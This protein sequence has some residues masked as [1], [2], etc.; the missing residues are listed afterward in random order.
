M[1]ELFNT[2]GTLAQ[3]AKH[4]LGGASG[5]AGGLGTLLTDLM[6]SARSVQGG[7]GS[8]PAPSRS[9]GLGFGSP[10]DS[11]FGSRNMS[12][13]FRHP[14]TGRVED[15]PGGRPQSSGPL[16]DLAGGAGGLLGSAALG[17]V[18]G[19]LL[20]NRK[21]RKVVAS[22][23]KNALLL[24]GGA[25]IAGMAWGMFKKWSENSAAAPSS[26]PLPSGPAS[27]PVSGL[28]GISGDES[29][30]HAQLIMTAMA[31]AAHCDGH[32]DEQEKQNMHNVAEGLGL[33]SDMAAQLDILMAAP[34]NPTIIAGLV[35]TP[36]EARDIYRLS[37]MIAHI[38]LPEER[39][40]MDSLATAI[41]IPPAEQQA[42]E[43]EISAMHNVDL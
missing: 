2:L 30:R 43:R 42:I 6:N 4:S 25:V 37:C 15:C 41:G 38:D 19:A 22:A 10:E 17:G 40:Y 26:A 35:R 7:V 8:A 29:E 24:G 13:G 11:D 5:G 14:L 27:I 23:G 18:L 1:K 21:A 39:K 31:F 3:Q 32:V 34:V 33:G 20:S 16:A 36:E 12:G 28:P 9:Q